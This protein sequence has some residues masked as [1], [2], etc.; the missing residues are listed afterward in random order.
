M[1]LCLRYGLGVAPD[2][3]ASG[4]DIDDI[5]PQP[6]QA[7]SGDSNSSPVKSVFPLAES[8]SGDHSAASPMAE[9]L[10]PS[11]SVA[12]RES[13]LVNTPQSESD[14]LDSTWVR[15]DEMPLGNGR[16]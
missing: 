12:N 14:D 2:A 1:A 7:G 9:D 5:P 16:L 11:S 4:M 6:V 13:R 10:R 8:V 15:P 3:Q